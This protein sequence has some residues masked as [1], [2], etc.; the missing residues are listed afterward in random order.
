MSDRSCCP[1]EKDPKQKQADNETILTRREGD[2]LGTKNTTTKTD[3]STSML[4]GSL[5]RQAPQ[6]SST[7]RQREENPH[8]DSWT[9]FHQLQANSWPPLEPSSQTG[10]SKLLS[11]D[12]DPTPSLCGRRSHLS[13][14]G[15]LTYRG[16]V[17]RG[18]FGR[19]V[20]HVQDT[21]A[22]CRVRH[23]GLVI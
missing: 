13:R 12:H 22:H 5:R 10:N 16:L 3:C 18:Q 9:C 23:L 2:W 11:K 17:G 15:V 8:L 21:D 7:A 4:P 19:V 1:I 14:L 6:R 20:V